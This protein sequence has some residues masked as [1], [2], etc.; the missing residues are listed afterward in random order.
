MTQPLPSQAR[1]VIVG[2]GAVGCSIAYHLTRGGEKDVLVLEKSGITHGATWHA[3]G[4]VGQLRTKRNLTRLMRNSVALY[5]KLAEETGQEIDWREVGS[6][7]LASSPARWSEI[8]RS[9]TAARSFGFDMEL[10]TAAEAKRL[11]P[12]ITTEGI[13]GAA[14][15][16][17]DGYVDP[18]GLAQAL[19]RGAR[20][21]GARIVEGVRVTGF[22]IERG[23]VGAVLTDHGRI[24]CEIAVNAAGLWARD[25]AKFCGLR[26][27]AAVVEHQYVVTEK[28][29]DMPK[30]LPTLRDPDNNFY[31]KP[32]VGAFAVGGWEKGTRGVAR[33]GMSFD[34]GRQLFDANMERLEQF[35]VPAATR[36]P[37][38]GTTGLRTVINGPIPISPDGEP[39]MGRMPEIENMFV[40]CGFTSGIA[41]AGGAGQALAGWILAG[42]PEFDLWAFDVRRFGPHHDGARYLY[43]RAID[44]YH[45][46]YLIHWPGEEPE[47][48][49][50]ARRSPLYGALAAQDASFGSRFGWERPNHFARGAQTEAE[51]PSFEGR[52]SWFDAVGAEHKAIRERVALIDQSSFSKFE[53][54]GPGAAAFLQRLASADMAKPPGRIVYT[55]LCN[56]KGGIEADLTF[57]RL[58]ED[59]YY[60]VTGSGFGVRD[61]GWIERHRPKDGTVALAD[62]TNAYAVLNLCGPRARDVLAAVAED[63]VSNAA[64]PYMAFKELRVGYAPVRAARVT[65]VGELGYE[66]HVPTEYALHLYETVMSAGA[67]HGIANA[68][69]RAIESCRLEKRYLYWGADITPDHN[70]Y[71][72][73]LG[74]AVALG[75]GDFIGRDALAKIKA[76]GPKQRLCGFLLDGDKPL[77][78]G[79]AILANGKVLGVT[80]SGG[81]GHTVGRWIAFGYV[82]ATEAKRQDFEIESFGERFAAKRID[83]CAYDPERRKL[84]A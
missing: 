65:Y 58:A 64:L 22:E 18:S 13:E 59:R 2:A 61:R 55:Q 21:G 8:K 43:E 14:F 20:K 7:R 69:Y 72:A 35:M 45:R 66:L 46:Y 40:A 62:V 27:P 47:V 16:P 32:D 9:A 78:G 56:P 23:R 17:S 63:D 31:L 60:V 74:F 3:A 6:L 24:A 51:R 42:E 80:S 33:A 71:E 41:A 73:G 15:I 76:E 75:K 68:G 81:Y 10:L 70:P 1:I 50:G 29:K 77:F 30:G 36:L 84:L 28:L 44:S 4:L 12:Y 39:I 53:I 82:P 11:F 54:S 57:M 5:R 49:R 37:A 19:A 83:G 34:F 26:L 38:L 48:A 25:V 52:P 79:E 67:A